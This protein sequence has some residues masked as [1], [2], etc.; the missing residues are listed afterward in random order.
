MYIKNNLHIIKQTEKSQNYRIVL[1]SFR[2]I[3]FLCEIKEN[4]KLLF[5]F[6]QTI[7]W[8]QWINNNFFPL[9]FIL[10][11]RKI[12]NEAATKFCCLFGEFY[13][14]G[15][16]RCWCCVCFTN[17]LL[18]IESNVSFVRQYENV[19][20]FNLSSFDFYTHNQKDISQIIDGRTQN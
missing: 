4:F 8:I 18:N 7:T 13:G 10:L 6:G 11:Y 12:L 17:C 9:K 15:V 3:S 20:V 5:F 2:F 19:K 14:I 1:L 16:G